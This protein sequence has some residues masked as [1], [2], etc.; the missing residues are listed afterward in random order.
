MKKIISVDGAK[1]GVGKS[2]FTTC[3]VDTAK[4]YC[5][6]DF[7]LIEA[8]DTN[9]DIYKTYH[10]LVECKCL[11]LDDLEGNVDFQNILQHTDKDLIIINNPARQGLSKHGVEMS[12]LL[13]E[14][15]YE[16]T[17]FWLCSGNPDCFALFKEFNDNFAPSVKKVICKNMHFRNTEIFD[18]WDES[19]LRV[20]IL[21]QENVEEI[22]FP[23]FSTRLSDRIRKKKR[24]WDYFNLNEEE[25]GFVCEAQ[26]SKRIFRPLLA[27][28]IVGEGE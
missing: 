28:Y 11:K 27:P 14:I 17:T 21:A 18:D 2:F 16:M 4:N 3:L 22:E 12:Y 13:P 8:D 15:G 1:G 10:E 25:F 26:K 6:K 9:S 24:A 19:Q 7:L 23:A 5:N 20:D